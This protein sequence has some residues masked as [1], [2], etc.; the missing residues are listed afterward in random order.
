MET[1]IL[2]EHIAKLEKEN[3]NLKEKLLLSEAN[4]I[5][6]EEVKE[7]TIK[8]LNSKNIEL[9]KAKNLIRESEEKY[10]TVVESASDGIAIMIDAS[11][12]YCNPSFANMLGYDS[13]ELIGKPMDLIISKK[14]K[15]KILDRYKK[16]QR[17]EDVP[18]RFETCLISKF[19][20]NMHMEI[21]AI[22]IHYGGKRA[23]LAI[24][25]DITEKKRT[26]EYTNFLAFHD[27]MTGLANRVKCNERI[28]DAIARAIKSNKKI[29]LLYMDLDNFKT[30]NDFMGHEAGDTVLQ[31]V[32]TRLTKC[33]RDVD[34]A[35]R[36]GGDEFV[37]LL[38]NIKE[39]KEAERVSKSIIE[40]LSEPFYINSRQ[41]N[42]GTSVGISIYPQ[43]AL[44]LD[45][46]Y[47]TADIAMYSS[48]NDGKNRYKFYSDCNK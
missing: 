45:T 27:S 9:E 24:L 17:G 43:D 4:R 14:E 23:E 38:E 7:R 19:K 15:N 44:D 6:L 48:K 39:P 13:S 12:Q 26:D 21:N 32:S 31:Q 22:T 47:R 25:R 1:D 30:I 35:A 40:M 8:L 29:A 18:I 28:E 36:V 11:F 46:L 20:K 2:N 5:M 34:L 41:C 3:R 10:R 16:V 42:I 33:I 37:V